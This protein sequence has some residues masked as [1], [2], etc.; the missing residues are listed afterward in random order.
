MKNF[1]SLK[2]AIKSKTFDCNVMSTNEQKQIKGGGTGDWYPTLAECQAGCSGS[3]STTYPH[4]TYP[5]E[6][7]Q[8]EPNGTGYSCTDLVS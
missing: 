8:C 3:G 5:G 7:F 6:N 1:K 2:E 4:T